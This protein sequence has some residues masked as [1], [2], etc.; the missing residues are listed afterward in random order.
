MN[1]YRK[2][3]VWEKTSH[4]PSHF[5]VLRDLLVSEASDCVFGKEPWLKDIMAKILSRKH[6]K[7][8]ITK[9]YYNETYDVIF[10]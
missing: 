3:I 9:G 6:R 8:F 10:Y 5:T 7:S 2:I 1:H 4:L